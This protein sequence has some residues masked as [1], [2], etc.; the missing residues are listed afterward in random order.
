LIL[1]HV[2]AAVVA[3]TFLMLH[4]LFPGG[5]SGPTHDPVQGLAPAPGTVAPDHAVAHAVALVLVLPGTDLQKTGLLETGLEIVIGHQRTGQDPGT[6]V[7]RT[8]LAPGTM[9]AP[10]HLQTALKAVLTPGLGQGAGKSA[11]SGEGMPLHLG[12][13]KKWSKQEVFPVF[14][15][16][17]FKFCIFSNCLDVFYLCFNN[18]LSVLQI[19]VLVFMSNLYL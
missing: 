6:E 12:S 19:Q 11:A 17:L 4:V 2:Q 18:V 10:V 9:D 3:T 13:L 5:C 1:L 8:G 14:E 15:H 16:C 7:L